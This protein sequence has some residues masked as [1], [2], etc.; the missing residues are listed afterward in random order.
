MASFYNLRAPAEP[1]VCATPDDGRPRRLHPRALA[2]SFW[3]LTGV[4]QKTA[5]KTSALLKC[6]SVDP[7]SDPSGQPSQRPGRTE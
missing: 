7:P 2:T 3:P 1:A 4:C 5:Q 6:F